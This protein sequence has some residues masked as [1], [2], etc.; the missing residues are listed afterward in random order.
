M[1]PVGGW[2]TQ[3]GSV[4]SA[5]GARQLLAGQLVINPPIDV[6]ENKPSK[7]EQRQNG[8][9]LESLLSGLDCLDCLAEK[10]KP[11]SKRQL[12]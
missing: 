5:H 3:R 9:F 11:E 4:H 8:G 1:V 6:F 10:G 2:E 12:S 7:E